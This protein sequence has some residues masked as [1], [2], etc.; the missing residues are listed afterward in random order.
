MDIL[1]DQ[2]FRTLIPPLSPDEYAGL[3]QSI[4]AEGNRVPIDTWQGYIVDGHNRYDICQKHNIPL[5]PANELALASREDVKIW[6]INNQLSRRNLPVALRIDLNIKKHEFQLQK[7][8]KERQSNSTGG[9]HPQLTQTFGD[10][11]KHEGEVDALI[12]KRAAVSRETVRK[13]RFIKEKAQPEQLDKLNKGD[14]TIN[15]VYVAVKREEVK[16]TVKHAEWPSGKYRII[17]ADPP[18][19]YSNSMP[20]DG[21]N[22]GH[23]HEQADHY[24]LMSLDDIT[25]MPVSEL[26]LD[27]AVLFLWS[28]SPILEDAFKVIN[29][30]GFKYKASFVWDKMKHNMG[31]FNSVRHEFL[32]VATRGSC[33][34]D[35]I[36]LFDSVQVIERNGHSEK[37]E[38]FRNIIQTL[39]PYGPRIELFARKK[40]DG[41]EVYGNQITA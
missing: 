34:P 27:N 23:F 18:W 7:E 11:E 5:K 17:Y 24:S 38:A 16:E 20:V 33:Q 9:A 25:K 22:T 30:W 3:E 14:A 1:I 31:H 8:A 37:P 39:Y 19:Q 41:W 12:G 6:I 40:T 36:E 4:I 21:E 15:Q 29:A 13:Y 26:S 35:N 28:T 10:A 2:E 32:L